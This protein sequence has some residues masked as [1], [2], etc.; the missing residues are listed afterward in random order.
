MLSGSAALNGNQTWISNV[1]AGVGITGPIV[2][3]G[4]ALSFAGSGNLM[5]GGTVSLTGSQTWTN[6]MSSTLAVY[7]PVVNNGNAL[8]LAGSGNTKLG[9]IFS[10]GNVTESGPG[11]TTVGLSSGYSGTLTLGGGTL[12][13]A[14]AGTT[15]NVQTNGAGQYT[16]IGPASDAGT[17]WNYVNSTSVTGKALFTSSSGATALT[18]TQSNTGGGQYSPGSSANKLLNGYTYSANGTTP[19]TET[20]SGLS[21]SVAYNLYV[22]SQNNNAA[23][24]GQYAITTGTVGGAITGGTVSGSAVNMGTS[25][26]TVSVYTTGINGN[27]ALFTDITPSAGQIVLTVSS[28]NNTQSALDGF[29]LVPI[30]PY[31]T[32]ASISSTASSTLDF[33]GALSGTVTGSVSLSNGATLTLQNTPAATLSGNIVTDASSTA[34]A[35]AAGSGSTPALTLAQTRSTS[36]P[37]ARSPCPAWRSC[38]RAER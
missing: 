10:T 38:P 11:T 23:N 35:L 31:T 28:P 16:G 30:V 22:M 3:P 19:F 17:T 33:S 5:I 34:L 14:S 25:P 20:I 32:G 13:L 37:A 8:T 2:N 4:Y 26:Q 18:L 36:A 7:G 15:I 6:N 29:Q 9:G 21:Q 12:V 27:T 24:I 1:S